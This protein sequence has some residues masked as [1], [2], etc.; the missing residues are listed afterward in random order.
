MADRIECLAKINKSRAND[1]IFLQAT[2][3]IVNCLQEDILGTVFGSETRVD[4]MQDTMVLKVLVYLG[5][6]EGFHDLCND[7][8][9]RNGS[10]FISS[11]GMGMT[12]AAFHS[13]GNCD[14]LRQA[15]K[16]WHKL[17][18]TAGA[19]VLSTPALTMSTPVALAGSS[20]VSATVTSSSVISWT[21]RS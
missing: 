12:V 4:F 7:R 19:V 14:V 13:N 11:F 2:S 9:N 10:V 15:L 5:V 6:Y 21:G 18:L 17:L 3:P 8:Q 20:L 1:F 16:R